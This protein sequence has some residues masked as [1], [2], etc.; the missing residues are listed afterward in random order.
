MS[1]SHGVGPGHPKMFGWA[2]MPLAPKMIHRVAHPSINQARSRAT[3]WFETNAL[4]LSQTTTHRSLMRCFLSRWFHNH[5][6]SETNNVIY[7]YLAWF[8]ADKTRC[9]IITTLS[10]LRLDTI[11]QSKWNILLRNLQWR[12]TRCLLYYWFNDQLIA[13]W[14]KRRMICKNTLFST[15]VY[16]YS[17]LYTSQMFVSL[18]DLATRSASADIFLLPARRYASA[19]LCD[20]DVS[21]R[22]S[23]TRRYCA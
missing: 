2:T 8:D 9:W 11:L 3:S 21:V 18:C 17:V 10:Y 14:H 7:T 1:K 4:S 23:V 22:L 13:I 12:V 20:S 5:L 16:N 19:G 6:I 15:P